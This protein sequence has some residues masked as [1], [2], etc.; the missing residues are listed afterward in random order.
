[1]RQFGDVL[2]TLGALAALKRRWPGRRLV[3]VVDR[4]FHSVLRPLAF[5]DELLDSPRFGE[6]LRYL[7]RIRS[8]TPGA[9][10]DF[11]GNSR[12]AL[13]AWLS[14]AAVRIGWDVRGRRH[15]YTCLLYTSPSPRDRT[16]S[17]MPS[18]A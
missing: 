2:A 10:I 16:R 1:M 18:S 4:H 12:S 5:I 8:M 17:R 6:Y 15:A 3:Y 9:V 13:L 7:A 14:G 11:H